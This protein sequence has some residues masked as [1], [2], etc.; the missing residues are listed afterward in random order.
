MECEDANSGEIFEAKTETQ[1]S[2][3]TAD[4]TVAIPVI[5]D[6]EAGQSIWIVKTHREWY[7][8]IHGNS[9]LKIARAMVE[10]VQLNLYDLVRLN[11]KAR[12]NGRKSR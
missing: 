7:N 12:A 6:M 4:S 9:V 2:D 3:L 11:V 5:F 10:M 8:N 1:K